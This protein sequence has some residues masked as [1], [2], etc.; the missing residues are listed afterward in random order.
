MFSGCVLKSES[1]GRRDVRYAEDTE[2][3]LIEHQ[4][5]KIIHQRARAVEPAYTEMFETRSLAQRSVASCFSNLADAPW[6]HPQPDHTQGEVFLMF[7]V[8]VL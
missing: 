5:G 1:S 7:T 4:S 2:R 8:A 6:E 3:R